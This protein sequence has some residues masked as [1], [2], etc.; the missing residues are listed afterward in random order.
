MTMGGGEGLDPAGAA[1]ALEEFEA[2]LKTHRAVVADAYRAFVAEDGGRP[3]SVEGGEAIRRFLSGDA[4]I[5][6][7]EEDAPTKPDVRAVLNRDFEELERR[8]REPDPDR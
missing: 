8:A 1:G 3:A 2:G 6:A 7:V 5:L 4:A